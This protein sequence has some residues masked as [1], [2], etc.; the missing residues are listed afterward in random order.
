[1][2]ANNTETKM[3]TYAPFIDEPYLKATMPVDVNVNWSLIRTALQD[4][5]ELYIRD[6]IGSGIYDVMCDQINDAGLQAPYI[7]L[8]NTYIAP[9]LARYVMYEC[10]DV[11]TFQA[12]NKGYQNRNSE[13]SNSSDIRDIT[14]MAL[15]YKQRADAFASK[16]TAYLVENRT[17][18]P[19]Y[20]NPGSGLDTVHP[21]ET[22]LFGGFYLG[23]SE[24]SCNFNNPNPNPNP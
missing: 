18:Y 3:S 4:A 22:H 6:L 10:A 12:T 5:Q 1:M 16:V 17:T 21:R 19:L 2:A 20:D 15:R 7:V 8:C 9:A 13:F 14:G 23:D 24:H 11:M